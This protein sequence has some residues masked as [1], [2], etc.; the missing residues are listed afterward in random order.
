MMTPFFYIILGF[1]MIAINLI[2]SDKIIGLF[3]SEKYYQ[4]KSVVKI[5]KRIWRQHWEKLIVL[6]IIWLICSISIVGLVIL[7]V[8][9]IIN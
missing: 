7:S 9:N 5:W 2:V 1:L 4:E 3:Y 8:Q 6:T